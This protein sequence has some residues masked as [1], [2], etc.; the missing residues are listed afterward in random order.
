MPQD[1]D[2]PARSASSASTF[3]QE[4]EEQSPFEPG[5]RLPRSTR[6][7]LLRLDP[8]SLGRAVTILLRHAAAL[9]PID[10]AG[11]AETI[12]ALVRGGDAGRTAELEV[13][14][15]IDLYRDLLGDRTRRAISALILRLIR[16]A[17]PEAAARLEEDDGRTMAEPPALGAVPEPTRGD[18][19]PAKDRRTDRGRR[20]GPGRRAR[21]GC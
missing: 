8:A 5:G 2:K 6:A 10:R 7:V 14:A 12:D 17:D 11:A 19:V 9:P 21:L 3:L 13:P 15:L 1:N 18:G 16:N 4:L 20:A